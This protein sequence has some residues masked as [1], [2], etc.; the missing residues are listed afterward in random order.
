VDF[1]I[2]RR[3]LCFLSSAGLLL[4]FISY[5]NVIPFSLRRHRAREYLALAHED[6][7]VCSAEKK[8][9]AAAKKA[10][11]ELEKFNFSAGKREDA[12]R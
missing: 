8:T 10:R 1:F 3:R 6:F 7:F 11:A 4:L 2:R 5:A 12:A 9:K